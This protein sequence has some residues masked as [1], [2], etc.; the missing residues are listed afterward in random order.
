MLKQFHHRLDKD[1]EP[2][3]VLTFNRSKGSFG[4]KQNTPKFIKGPIPFVWMAKANTLPG[5][6]GPVGLGLWFLVGVKGN[7]IFKL[8]GEIESLAGCERKAVANALVQLE[9]AGLIS[10]T[11]H[12]GSRP[13]ITILDFSGHSSHEH[14]ADC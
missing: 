9:Q 1:T 4:P 8:T 2:V 10:V 14:P 5:K 6:A 13:T 7:R 12:S 3:E 11:R